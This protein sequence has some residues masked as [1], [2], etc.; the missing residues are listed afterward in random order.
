MHYYTVSYCPNKAVLNIG[1]SL[2]IENDI[3]FDLLKESICEAYDR[4]ECMRI[5]FCK[6][7]NG[8]VMQYIVPKEERD[9]EFFGFDHW[10]LCRRNNLL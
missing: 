1:T 10:K 6:N 7:E 4:S 8:E 5:R 3:N 9:I 2:T